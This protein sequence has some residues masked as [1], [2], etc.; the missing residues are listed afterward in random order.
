MEREAQIRLFLVD[1]HTLFRKGL[2]GLLEMQG[3]LAVAGEAADG[4]D[5]LSM[6]QNVDFD[7]VLMDVDM[8]KINGF[9]AS[10]RILERRPDTKIIALSMHSEEDYYFKMVSIGVKGFLLKNSSIDEV[11]HAIDAVLEGGSYFSQ[12]LLTSLVSNLKTTSNEEHL[13]QRE[14]EIL[15]LICQGLSNSEIGDKLFISK[16]TVDKHRA[17]IL[18]KSGCK[19]TANLV[20]WAIKNKIVMI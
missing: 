1:D 16:R 13:S 19:N 14:L 20:V 2:G 17:N 7:V 4:A 18:E 15:L 6:S 10:T 5:F 8:P 12:E 9:E 3:G 11:C